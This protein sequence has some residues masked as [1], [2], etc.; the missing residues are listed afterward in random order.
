MYKKC[1][2]ILFYLCILSG[3]LNK[4]SEEIKQEENIEP[5]LPVSEGYI[6]GT[7]IENYDT[8][9]YA[10]KITFYED[11][12]FTSNLNVCKAMIDVNGEYILADHKIYLLFSQS[13][14]FD[15]IDKNQPYIFNYTEDKLFLNSESV[16]YSCAYVDKYEKE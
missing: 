14:G 7:F 9:E 11:G 5:T 16:P 13:T 2:R 1:F 4:H 6:S 3:C 12:T 15:F 8:Y 10:T